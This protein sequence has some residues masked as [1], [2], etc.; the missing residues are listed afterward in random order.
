MNLSNLLELDARLSAQARLKDQ[1][2]SRHK[3]AGLLAHSGD[4]WFWLL[5][6]ILLGYLAGPYWRLRAIVF[7]FGI[8]VTAVVVLTIK[9]T[10][11]RNRPAGQWGEIYRKS[12]PHSF[13]S[14]HAARGAMLAMVAFGLGP[15]WLGVILLF[16][17][18][19]MALARVLMG[20]HY[21]SDV[22]VGVL[23]GMFMGVIILQF[24]LAWLSN[25]F[26]I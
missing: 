1:T 19:L 6:L 18:P 15:L 23:L 3:I 17:A 11:R 2:G 24:D 4:S 12:D 26:L 7:G 16:W 13:P 21:W 14:G 22:V 9:F 10:V 8:V 5:G 20:V 25:F